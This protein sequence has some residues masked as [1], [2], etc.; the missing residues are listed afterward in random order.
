MDDDADVHVVPKLAL[1]QA[2]GAL[3]RH[4]RTIPR[5]RVFC[6]YYTLALL[7]TLTMDLGTGYYGY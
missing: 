1:L 5:R 2:V 6:Y 7:E 4:E 3:F